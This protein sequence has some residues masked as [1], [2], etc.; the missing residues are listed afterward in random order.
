MG[1]VLKL[2]IHKCTWILKSLQIKSLSLSGEAITNFETRM[3]YKLHK[4]RHI[5]YYARI[6]IKEI[7]LCSM[8]AIL[9]AQTAP[10][11]GITSA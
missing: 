7:K 9:L 8:H 1:S 5:I 3:E 4:T 10:Q 11:Y 6:N 2:L